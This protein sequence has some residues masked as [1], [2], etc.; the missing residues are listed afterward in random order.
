M[1]DD[2]VAWRVVDSILLNEAPTDADAVKDLGD[3]A[4][5]TRWGQTG[6]WLAQ[7]SLPI[8]KTREEAASNYRE[9]LDATGIDRLTGISEMLAYIVADWAVWTSPSRAIRALQ[10]SLSVAEDGVLG[11]QTEAAAA[12]ADLTRTTFRV[13]VERMRYTNQIVKDHPDRN[14]QWLAG[15]DEREFRQLG[16]LF[17]V[18]L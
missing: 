11:P 16:D 9:W 10:K 12:H 15:W 1:I 18:S 17:G 13:L 14:L 7:Y 8:P 4:G 5:V 6:S 2:A 3:G